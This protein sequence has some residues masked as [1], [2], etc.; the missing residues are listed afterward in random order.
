V[1]TDAWI[2]DLFETEPRGALQIKHKGPLEMFFLNGSVGSSHATEMV[3][4][5]T[6]TS[7]RRATGLVVSGR[8]PRHSQMA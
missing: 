6:T 2:K 4:S 5:P 3:V 8:R 1:H 7:P